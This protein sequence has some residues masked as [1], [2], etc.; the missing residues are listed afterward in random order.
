[1]KKFLTL[2]AFT[3]L[4]FIG[5]NDASANEVK[6]SS[7]DYVN[8]AI[9]KP[10]VEH[11]DYLT[12]E[13]I[14]DPNTIDFLNGDIF[15]TANGNAIARNMMSATVIVQTRQSFNGA[16]W[17]MSTQHW[18]QTFTFRQSLTRAGSRRNDVPTRGGGFD[19][20]TTFFFNVDGRPA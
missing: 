19:R 1:M 3:G 14:Q 13:R 11:F 12:G 2:M 6:E 18:H 10:V 7:A 15:G 20:T 8:Q 17:I 5:T 4:F 9:P 16:G